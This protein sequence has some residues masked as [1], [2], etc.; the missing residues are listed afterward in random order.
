MLKKTALAAT[1]LIAVA[2][3][4]YGY[5]LWQNNRPVQPP[6]NMEFRHA[7][8][9]ATDW[10]QRNETRLLPHNNPMLWRMIQRSAELTGDPYL[11]HLFAAYRA[12]HVRDGRA[13]VWYPLFVEHAWIPVR[14]E[15]IV[16][17]PDYNKL[18]IYAI[19]C[20]SDLARQP[21]IASQLDAGFC[22]GLRLR[23]ACATHQLMG[24]RLLQRKGCGEPEALADIVASLQ[25]RIRWQLVLDPRVVDVYLQRV[26]MLV[27]SGAGERVKPVWLRRVLEAQSEDG[28]WSAGDPLLELPGGRVVAFSGRGVTIGHLKSDFH[29]TA[30]GVLLMSL[31]LYLPSSPS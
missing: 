5:L 28:G 6:D 10:L 17:L 12:R 1:V 23:P 14:Y 19:T 25:E 22:G 13:G 2:A 18:F 30:Q 9:A 27:E 21:D 11:R 8:R 4:F 31:L 20:D 26:L 24:I 7:L 29:A 15:D 3:G 16:D